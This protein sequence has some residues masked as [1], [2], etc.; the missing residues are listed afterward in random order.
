[1]RMLYVGDVMGE[2]GIEVVEKIVPGLRRDKKIDLV[3]AQAENVTNGRGISPTDLKRLRAAGID[4]FT[5]GNHTFDE[6]SIFPQLNDPGQ[7]IIRPANYPAGTPGLGYKYI[8]TAAGKV[9]VISLL[10]Q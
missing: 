7:P 2:V 10:G 6:E 3:I 4:F 1:M 5:G 9:L 8:E